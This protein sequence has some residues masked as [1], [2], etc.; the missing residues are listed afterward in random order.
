MEKRSQGAFSSISPHSLRHYKHWLTD[1]ESL[2]RHPAKTM[3]DE[4][5]VFLGGSRQVGGV[6]IYI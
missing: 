5:K 3:R 4:V 2:N 1:L 6:Y